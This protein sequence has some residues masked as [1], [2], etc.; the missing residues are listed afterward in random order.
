[1]WTR[2]DL[3]SK[4]KISF[5]A[6]YWRAVLVSLILFFIA[7]GTGSRFNF[8]LEDNDFTNYFHHNDSGSE[9]IEQI[10][11]DNYFTTD[12]DELINDIFFGDEDINNLID[13]YGDSHNNSILN[14]AKEWALENFVNYKP[15]MGSLA[16]LIGIGV[17]FIFSLGIV[18]KVFLFNPLE[19][20]CKKFFVMNLGE[21]AGL[22]Y[23]GDGFKEDYI[24]GVKTMFFR[25]LYNLLWFFLLIIPGIIKAYEYRM[26]PYILAE[27]PEISTSEAFAQS[28][29]MMK[30]NKWDTF[31]LDLSFI[32]WHLLSG[33]TFNIAGILYVNPYVDETNAALYDALRTSDAGYGY[34]TYS[35]YEE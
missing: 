28:K 6:N 9:Y 11:T 17:V 12:D 35:D 25:D 23:I 7:G 14:G 22:G 24:N 21:E 15:W 16:A 3:K 34:N 27:N 32:L 5:K 29:A 10:S 19:I 20:G 13:P 31:V 1:M 2:R 18:L 4:A 30:G 33:I 8:N 26:I